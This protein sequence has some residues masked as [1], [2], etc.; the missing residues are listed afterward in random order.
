MALATQFLQVNPINGTVATIIQNGPYTAILTIAAKSS[1]TL[2]TRPTKVRFFLKLATVSTWDI[3]D[4][5]LKWENATDKV[6][7]CS[8][9]ADELF[10]N[11]RVSIS[12]SVK[13][14]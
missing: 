12:T 8:I 2:P 14:R 11:R 7:V 1:T 9:K 3:T 4:S 6:W 13:V 10:W 5:E